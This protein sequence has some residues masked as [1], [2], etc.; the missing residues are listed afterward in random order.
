MIRGFNPHG[1]KCPSVNFYSGILSQWPSPY[2]QRLK[3]NTVGAQNHQRALL[4][5]KDAAAV[6]KMSF[7]VG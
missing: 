5:I 2:A 1:S 6:M 3:V 4:L 7:T